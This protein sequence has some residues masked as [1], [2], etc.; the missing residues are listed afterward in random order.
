MIAGKGLF[1]VKEGSFCILK[2]EKYF[3]S[4][5]GTG[6]GGDLLFSCVILCLVF[7]ATS[8]AVDLDVVLGPETGYVSQTMF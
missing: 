7:M 5:I 2:T 8:Q 3:S 4:N 1:M 6:W